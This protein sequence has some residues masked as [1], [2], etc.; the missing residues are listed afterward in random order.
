MVFVVLF[1]VSCGDKTEDSN[2]TDVVNDE[3][4]KVDEDA[5]ELD[6][7]LP[8][9][10]DMSDS[11][12][13]GSQDD[14]DEVS[15][16]ESPDMNDNQIVDEDS[17]ETTDDDDE[18]MSDEA[19]DVEITDDDSE[20]AKFT[21]IRVIEKGGFFQPDKVYT[22]GSS[23]IAIVED[24]NGGGVKIIDLSGVE[25]CYIDDS[26]IGVAFD[27]EG[28]IYTTV[29]GNEV[30]KYS[31]TCTYISKGGG[32]GTE[33]G[34]FIG[35]GNIRFYNNK[36]YVLDKNN[37]RIQLLTKDLA[38]DS[39]LN[40]GTLNKPALID[41]NSSG[42]ISVYEEDY[43]A[44]KVKVYGSDLNFAWSVDD[45]SFVSD[46][47]LR[48]DGSV[49]ITYSGKNCFRVY[50]NG[51]MTYMFGSWGAYSGHL[52]AQFD[53]VSSVT[54]MDDDSLYIA[55]KG[56]SRLKKFVN[57]TTEG[58]LLYSETMY[59]SDRRFTENRSLR[60]D[61][62]DH[63]FFTD[64]GSIKVLDKLGDK[65]REVVS[66]GSGDVNLSSPGLLILDGNFM[67]TIDTANNFFYSFSKE[68]VFEEK[69]TFLENIVRGIAV[70]STYFYVI[71]GDDLV[72]YPKSDLSTSEIITLN[73]IEGKILK[74]ASG[75]DGVLFAH[76]G[77]N[78]CRFA[79][80]TSAP[81]CVDY[82]KPNV[83]TEDNDGNLLVLS[84]YALKKF[85]KDLIEL[86]VLSR[87][88]MGE[89]Y[90]L[91]YG[92]GLAVDS[93]GYVYIGESTSARSKITVIDLNF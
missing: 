93:D 54:K 67:Y 22:D 20:S 2:D 71:E 92:T 66:T 5:S 23:R 76:N 39:V 74:I 78:L 58:E 52:E 65:V 11:N 50:N 63:L 80:A 27:D 72:R 33:N 57:S 49:V 16:D 34:Q 15:Q 1:V 32:S 14:K 62:N 85:D 82:I 88:E 46:V 77:L 12:S 51:S 19:E 70:D 91:E 43:S 55:D 4:V 7:D 64:Q 47:A 61:G 28:N 17:E 73:G 69:A 45:V 29:F 44:R 25:K 13:D 90:F 87:D 3:P 48:N 10:N 53:I 18:E 89:H 59:G 56:N 79:N 35:I 42:Q 30:K 81:V 38:F 60:I 40:I 36:L 37:A 24:K 83:M 86:G 9:D 6:E 21:F 8:V 75:K 68:G 26:A 41:I 84:D 31:S